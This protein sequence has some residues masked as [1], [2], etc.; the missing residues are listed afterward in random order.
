M[1]I[2]TSSSAGGDEVCVTTY[3]PTVE[4]LLV[5]AVPNTIAFTP[6]KAS[7][8]R[9]PYPSGSNSAESLEN[10]IEMEVKHG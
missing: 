4:M 3:T 5:G 2:G 9:S 6:N 8:A 7:R 1:R 10:L